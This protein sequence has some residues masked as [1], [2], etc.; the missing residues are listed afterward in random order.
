MADNDCA[1]FLGKSRTRLPPIVIRVAGNQ[2][3]MSAPVTKSLWRS[4]K[5]TISA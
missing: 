3:V 4:A 2:T 5:L 1:R